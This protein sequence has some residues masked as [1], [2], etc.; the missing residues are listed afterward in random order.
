MRTRSQAN[1]KRKLILQ[2]RPSGRW[3]NLGEI[4]DYDEAVPAARERGEI[5]D[6]WEVSPIDVNP[7]RVIVA[8]DRLH[9]K[10]NETYNSNQTWS[11]AKPNFKESLPLPIKS[12]GKA[13]LVSDLPEKLVGVPSDAAFAPKSPPPPVPG[14]EGQEYNPSQFK[15]L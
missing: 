4:E 15:L 5:P 14:S 9:V 11:N 12:K 3:Y 1:Q 2:V 7:L 10:I 13:T 8:C 6:S